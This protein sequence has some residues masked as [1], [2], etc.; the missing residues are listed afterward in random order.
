MPNWAKMAERARGAITRNLGEG[1]TYLPA[2]GGTYSVRGVFSAQFVG[3]D[4]Q[5]G[6]EV[7]SNTPNVFVS[8]ADIPAVVTIDEDHFEREGKSYLVKEEHLDGEGGATY[9][10]HEVAA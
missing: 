6:S 5:T 10:L 3:V 7:T 2:A 9:M 8:L 1:V 4:L